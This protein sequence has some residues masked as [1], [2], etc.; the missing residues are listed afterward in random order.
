MLLFEGLRPFFIIKVINLEFI[1][2]IIWTYSDTFAEMCAPHKLS[3][4]D[5]HLMN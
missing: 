2:I 3:Y 1:F 5:C 4:R